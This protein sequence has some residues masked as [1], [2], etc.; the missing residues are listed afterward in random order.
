MDV[1][2]IGSG[3]VA[4]HLALAL[5]KINQP[6]LQIFARNE[7]DLKAIAQAAAIPYSTFEL[8]KA[9]LYLI[10]VSDRSI[11]AASEWITDPDALVAHTSGSM[12]ME[13]LK[14]PYRK[15]CFYP[16]QTFSKKKELDFK[17]IPIFLECEFNKDYEALT[18][19]AK[20]LSNSVESA[21]YEKRKYIHLT[22]VFACNFVNHLYARAKEISDSQNLSFDYFR[23][24][25][26]ETLEKTRYLDP[27]QAQTGP[28]VRN[29]TRV[30]QLH[31]AILQ[32][33]QQRKLYQTLNESIEEMYRPK[34]D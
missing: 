31:E 8:K 10:C 11:Q 16:L 17:S 14:G 9:D 24:L 22:A 12:P 21:D 7:R 27:K 26:E 13:S 18:S 4:H 33:P 23:P 29:D 5:T 3:N 32:T 25:M 28:A 30:L 34:K 6:A 19:L 2:I 15:A 20:A 1:V